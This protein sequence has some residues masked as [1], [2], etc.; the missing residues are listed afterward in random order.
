MTEVAFSTTL[1]GFDEAKE[2]MEKIRFHLEE[3]ERLSNELNEIK[4][5]VLIESTTSEI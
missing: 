2:K 1:S 5:E 4:C 3:A